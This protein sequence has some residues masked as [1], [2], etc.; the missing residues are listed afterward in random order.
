MLEGERS[1]ILTLPWELRKLFLAASFLVPPVYVCGLQDPRLG[2]THPHNGLS[3]VTPVEWLPGEQ[4]GIRSLGVGIFWVVTV[5]IT[6][7]PG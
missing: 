3:L 1:P 7:G 5:T 4:K 6:Q 2:T